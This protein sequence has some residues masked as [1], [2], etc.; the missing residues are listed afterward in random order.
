MRHYII[1][2][3]GI[4][5]TFYMAMIYGSTSIALLG[6]GEAVFVVISFCYLLYL[7]RHLQFR[8]EVPITL[9]ERGQVSSVRIAKS[10][11]ILFAA[12]KVKYLVTI[13]SSFQKKMQ[14]KWLSGEYGQTEE[15]RNQY[16][17][18]F[19]TSGNYEIGL[20]QVRIYD[21][22]GLFYLTQ[23]N[24]GF[25]NV[26]IIPDIHEAPVRLTER[27]RNFFGDADVYDEKR[28]GQDVNEVFQIRPFQDGDK[29]QSVHWKLS[30][31]TDELMVKE[32]SMPKACPVVLILDSAENGN[33]VRGK[34]YDRMK[35]DAFFSAAASISFSI[36][37][38]GCPHY[39]A[40]YSGEEKD[41]VRVRVDDE[42]SFYQFLS[43]FLSEGG[44]ENTAEVYR[45][46][47]QKY[48]SEFLLHR[49]VLNKRLEL[50][51]GEKVFATLHSDTLERELGDTE[52]IL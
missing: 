22:T 51:E 23:K 24:K 46:Y 38:A 42:E 16:E 48:R 6:F 41:V 14:K 21:L 30:A 12:S 33:K 50:A 10:G 7:K 28:P 29:I 5:I 31:R 36:M 45:L 20:K 32:S 1:A 34:H 26:E 11:H 18:S 35:L 17:L 19:Q 9:A 40:W 15:S 47:Q 49:Y 39:V 25:G 37:D 52:F 4:A 27:A 8:I 3:L 44:S 13:R 2:I 43:Y